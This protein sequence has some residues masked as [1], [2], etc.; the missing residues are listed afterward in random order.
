MRLLIVGLA[1]SIHVARW[2]RQISDQGWDI[3]FFPSVDTGTVHPELDHVTV[4]HSIYHIPSNLAA[5]PSTLR[6]RGLRLRVPFPRATTYLSDIGR[7]TRKFL[8]TRRPEY[9]IRQLVRLIEE[10]EPDVIHAMEFQAAGYLTLEAKQRF[11]GT[12]PPWIVTNY[13]SDIYLF[14][15][16]QVHRER[17]KALLAA[18]D[19][20]TCECQRDVEL[21][22]ALGFRGQVLDVLPVGGGFD[23]ADAQR[24]RSPGLTSE[25]RLILIKGYQHW[26]GRA[27]VALRALSLCADG[28]HGYRIAV[29]LPNTED[30][31]IQA[32]L[33]SQQ[34]GIPIEM[35]S[36]ISHEQMLRLQGQARIHLGL[37][38]S[39]G[40]STSSLE[41]MLMGAFPIQSDTAC[42]GEWFEDGAGG[43]LVPPEDPA[44]VADALRR[45]LSDD[46]LVD[47][48]AE[49]NA[50]VVADRLDERHLR[51]RLANLYRAAAR[52]A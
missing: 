18:C 22:R 13:G 39:D 16:L 40:I 38:I 48:A 46:A 41:A 51:E 20:Y 10:L 52:N 30:V 43:L 14:G 44:V 32:E 33:V 1:D 28:L 49:R 36:E 5:S 23:L 37:S 15:R 19:Y 42:A 17:V 25:R 26:A 29:H 4:H 2:I 7:I 12:F 34:I 31:S 27:L 24:W 8:Q 3:H 47:S 11:A 45:A 35:I 50:G 21:A 9:R 6:R